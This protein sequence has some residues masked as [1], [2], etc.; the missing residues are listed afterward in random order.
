MRKSKKIF[1]LLL[2]LMLLLMTGMSSVFATDACVTCGGDGHIVNCD[3]ITCDCPDCYYYNE[4]AW[5]RDCDGTSVQLGGARNWSTYFAVNLADI[6][7]E[8]NVSFALYAGQHDHVGF[9]NVY[10][11]DSDTLRVEYHLYGD[12]A[13]LEVTEA[14]IMAVD[15]PA[16]F[17]NRNGNLVPG[18]FTVKGYNEGPY[19][20]PYNDVNDN[21]IIYLAVHAVVEGW[22]CE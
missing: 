14:H 22:M 15:D 13:D 12:F 2:V 4:T 11:I 17:P 3:G 16:N 20:V 1:S 9:V 10:L 19:Y 18:Q 8:E 21:D 7:E 6:A 5:A